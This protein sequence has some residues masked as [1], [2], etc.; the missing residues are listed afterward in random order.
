VRVHLD[1]RGRRSLYITANA[2]NEISGM[3]LEEGRALHAQLIEYI[4]RPEFCYFHTW[5]KGDLVVWDNRTTLH[6]AERYDMTRY[7]RVL[8]RTTVAGDGP[9]FGPC[10]LA[11]KA[12][13]Y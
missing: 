6:K 9:V 4:A 1:A 13:G 10:S 8:R 5:K 3:S 11:V 7:R 12:A 2:G